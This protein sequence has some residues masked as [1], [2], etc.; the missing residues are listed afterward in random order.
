LNI[1]LLLWSYTSH[2]DHMGYC[3]IDV[4]IN[5]FIFMVTFKIHFLWFLNSFFIQSLF[6][7]KFF[8]WFIGFIMGTCSN[9]FL[10][11]V[12]YVGALDSCILI[13]LCSLWFPL[14]R[15]K[16]L[17][18]LLVLPISCILPRGLRIL[19]HICAFLELLFLNRF[20]FS[21]QTHHYSWPLVKERAL[22]FEVF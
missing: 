21:K 7:C 9:L 11:Q 6:A 13:L 18:R 20:F 22:L 1:F 5:I 12:K 8:K 10:W 16:P 3:M 2:M 4:E 14:S 19:W 15:E 17:L